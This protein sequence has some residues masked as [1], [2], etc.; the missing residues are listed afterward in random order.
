MRLVM[1]RMDVESTL[2]KITKLER[3]LTWAKAKENQGRRCRLDS[4][5]ADLRRDRKCHNKMEWGYPPSV[6][7]CSSSE[8]WLSTMKERAVGGNAVTTC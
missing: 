7:D 5:V 3:E 8:T 1:E 2:K 6:G 4:S